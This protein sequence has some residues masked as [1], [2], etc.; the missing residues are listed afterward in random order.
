MMCSPYHILFGDEIKEV[1]MM[2]WAERVAR[3]GEKGYGYKIL[4]RNPERN[5]L[6]GNPWR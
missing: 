4:V 2:R 6:L 3:M 5:R 1:E